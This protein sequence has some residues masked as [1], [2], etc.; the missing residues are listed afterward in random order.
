MV[1]FKEKAKGEAESVSVGLFT[2]PVLQA[3]DV[4]AYRAHGVPV[5]E[6]QRQHIELMRDLAQRFNSA[7]EP[8]FVLPEP[9]VPPR[10]ARI[11]ALDDPTQKMSKSSSRP[12]S[13]IS[14]TD[15]PDLI[16]RKVRAAVTDSGREV[17][18]AD[19]KPAIS[20]LLTIFAALDDVPIEQLQE[21]FAGQGYGRFKQE[22]ADAL[23]ARLTPIRE[24]FERLVDDRA[25]LARTLDSGAEQAASVAGETLRSAQDAV[26]LLP[27]ASA[28]Q[29]V[30]DRE[31]EPALRSS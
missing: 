4:L 26:G 9:W 25:E 10:A 13:A 2:Y 5:G 19:D 31:A 24:R 30:E 8:V 18:V 3:A 11:M 20:N 15:A 12:D 22:L 28:E 1:Q 23:V 17:R 21:R 16:Q 14:L 27:R 6:D 7:F 29:P